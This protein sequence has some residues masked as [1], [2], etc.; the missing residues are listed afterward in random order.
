MGNALHVPFAEIEPWPDA[1]GHLV[2]AGVVPIALD[3]AADGVE[4]AD[5]AS[6]FAPAAD[7]RRPALIVGTEGPGVRGETLE[8]VRRVGGCVARIGIDA[9]ADSLNVGVAAAIALREL[10][11][12]RRA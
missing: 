1:L 4:V 2:E 7:G 5:L 9:G 11:G 10:G 8:A 6:E 12:R 3:P